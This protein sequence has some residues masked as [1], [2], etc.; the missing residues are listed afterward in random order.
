MGTTGASDYAILEF[1]KA[2]SAE[3]FSYVKERLETIL[4]VEFA[5]PGW[6]QFE[7]TRGF[8]RDRD[9]AKNS[10][11]FVG[12][13]MSLVKK[14][15]RISFKYEAREDTTLQLH[16]VA[17]D[18]T[19]TPTFIFD[20][21]ELLTAADA[22]LEAFR[23]REDLHNRIVEGFN[24]SAHSIEDELFSEVPIKTFSAVALKGSLKT[25]P[26]IKHKPPTEA[27]VRTLSVQ[28]FRKKDFKKAG[29]IFH[30]KIGGEAA[31][32]SQLLRRL[33]VYASA[34]RPKILRNDGQHKN[35]YAITRLASSGG[36][37]I[38]YKQKH[39]HFA[40]VDRISTIEDTVHKG[41]VYRA[42]SRIAINI[43]G[44]ESSYAINGDI[45]NNKTTQLR[46]LTRAA[47]SSYS[48]KR[49][50]IAKYIALYVATSAFVSLST[51]FTSLVTLSGS[52]FS[53]VLVIGLP[54]LAIRA[55]SIRQKLIE[56]TLVGAFPDIGGAISVADIE[57]LSKEKLKELAWEVI[58]LGALL[59]EQKELLENR[60][61]ATM[62][63]N[64]LT[65]LGNKLAA[66]MSGSRLTATIQLL[67]TNVGLH[68]IT[69]SKTL[70]SVASMHV[71]YP[72]H[73]KSKERFAIHMAPTTKKPEAKNI[74]PG[75]QSLVLNTF[76]DPAKIHIEFS[77]SPLL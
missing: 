62:S 9:K 4:G 1:G 14:I 13:H 19:F 51:D 58:T 72:E 16:N 21:S 6:E 73:W 42:R 49:H 71:T 27:I 15:G 24:S 57:S 45:L 22:L 23:E 30:P 33:D 25:E 64:S 41:V 60:L 37:E 48:D 55:M 67:S 5:L 10:P 76:S 61:A 32:A 39:H 63:G 34:I 17:K 59:D 35:E 29:P 56:T 53:S 65:A 50:L 26:P 20:E 44:K 70:E 3:L 11:V 46:L 75:R 12:S 40:Q 31:S 77:S 69:H 74:L 38:I 8:F 43:S 18:V 68:A 28:G 66:S 47:A 36:L 54:I 2:V 52:E 7:I